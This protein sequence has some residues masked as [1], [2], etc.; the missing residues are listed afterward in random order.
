MR[1]G[2]TGSIACGKTTVCQHL[3]RIGYP[4][5]DADEISR[6]IIAENC[7][8]LQEIADNFGTSYFDAAGH[9]KRID[10][11]NLIFTDKVAREKLNRIIH[12]YILVKMEEESKK[13]IQDGYKDI[14]LDIPL[15]V[16]GK[17]WQQIDRIWICFC[18]E[19][20]QLSRIIARD[21]CSEELARKKIMAQQLLNTKIRF[22]DEI[23]NSACSKTKMFINVEKLCKEL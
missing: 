17:L 2:I 11:G 3:K 21:N 9:V 15:L 19:K 23:V 4:I 20:L 22:A 18:P 7:E 12:P 13:F 6:Q 10:L 14:F 8:V 5:I 1:V 16:E